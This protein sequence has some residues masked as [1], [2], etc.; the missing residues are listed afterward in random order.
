[1]SI[2][3][4]YIN[5]TGLFVVCCVCHSAAV[6]LWDGREYKMPQGNYK[7]RMPVSG[8]SS[9]AC[10]DINWLLVVAVFYCTVEP[11]NADTLGP[12]VCILII[13]VVLFEGLIYVLMSPL[14]LLHVS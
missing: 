12:S 6:A 10:N 3:D 9:Y 14:G 13:E 2:C 1:M 8:I 5:V 4:L 11:R 7:V